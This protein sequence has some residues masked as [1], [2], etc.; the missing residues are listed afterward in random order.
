MNQK[1]DLEQIN[2]HHCVK[3]ARIRSFSGPYFHAFGL[4]MERHGVPLYIQFE[5]GKIRTRKTPNADTFHAVHITE[6]F[7][8]AQNSLKLT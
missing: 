4:S 1:L 5:C 6:K 8:E 2:P 7:G 3:S